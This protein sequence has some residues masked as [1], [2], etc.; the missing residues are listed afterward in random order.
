MQGGKKETP[1]NHGRSSGKAFVEYPEHEV[2]EKNSKH[3]QYRNDYSKSEE[4][5]LQHHDGS[6]TFHKSTVTYGNADGSYKFSST[7]RMT[8]SDGVTFVESKVA[9]TATSQAKHS[10]SGGLYDKGHSTTG[11]LNSDCKVDTKQTLPNLTEDEANELFR[12]EQSWKGNDTPSWSENFIGYDNI[13]EADEPAGFEQSEAAEISGFEQSW[14]GNDAPGWSENF[15]SYDN[16]D[17]VEEDSYAYHDDYY[18][19]PY[20]YHDEYYL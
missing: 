2:E 3:V 10:I 4:I 6:F 12:F 8:G 17:V 20:E 19:D 14:N 5:Q 9:E 1:C 13:D 18:P 11:K 16:I 7:I 15:N